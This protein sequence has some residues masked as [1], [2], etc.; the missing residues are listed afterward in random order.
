M[1][2]TVPRPRQRRAALAVGLIVGLAAALFTG[3]PATADDVRETAPNI[4]NVGGGEGDAD[5]DGV[6][7]ERDACADTD[8]EAEADTPSKKLKQRRLWSTDEGFVNG[9]GEVVFSL[10]ETGGCSATQIIATA[11]LGKGH[12]K[13][14][15]S[16]GAMKAWIKR[17]D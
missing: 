17:L 13:H 5:G 11:K 12:A 14:G 7:D 8:L 10:D 6:P 1:S 4:I 2:R 15:I 3:L 16:A 9:S